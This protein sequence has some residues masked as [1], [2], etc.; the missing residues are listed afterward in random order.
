MYENFKIKKI[1]EV[2]NVAARIRALTG[3]G[4]LMALTNQ[5]WKGT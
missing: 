5:V 1:P 2:T 3:E 4:A